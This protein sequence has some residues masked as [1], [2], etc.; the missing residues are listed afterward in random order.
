MLCQSNWKEW[1]IFSMFFIFYICY[2][3]NSSFI[4]S[5]PSKK[6]IYFLITS[7]SFQA[8]FLPYWF[9]YND[10]KIIYIIILLFNSHIYYSGVLMNLIFWPRVAHARWRT[11][12]W[13]QGSSQGFAV[14]ICWL[15]NMQL[16]FTKDPLPDS[17]SGDFQNLN[18]LNEQVK[19]NN[20][21]FHESAEGYRLNIDAARLCFD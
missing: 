9:I 2:K 12:K 17:V 19:R 16:H 7:H 3:Q 18:K 11:R 20:I 15:R 8:S 5:C 14:S 6:S 13:T 4:T 21:R 10:S 1:N